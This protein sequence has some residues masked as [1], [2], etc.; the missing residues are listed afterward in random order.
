MK[1][2][3]TKKL[4]PVTTRT[5]ARLYHLRFPEPI[6]EWLEAKKECGYKSG[7]AF[8]TEQV[9]QVWEQ[10]RVAKAA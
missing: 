9:R 5:P 1:A 8:I 2:T 7:A 6:A 3:K 10:E 4:P